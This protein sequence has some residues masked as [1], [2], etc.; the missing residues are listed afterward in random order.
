[1]SAEYQHLQA[2]QRDWLGNTEVIGLEIFEKVP[3]DD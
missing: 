3:A 1:M 2:V